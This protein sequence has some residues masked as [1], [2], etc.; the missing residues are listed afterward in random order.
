MNL[1]QVAAKRAVAPNTVSRWVDA[2]FLR[3]EPRTALRP[4]LVVSRD[5][6]ARF[7]DEEWPRIVQHVGTRHL[8]HWSD[9]SDRR[10][11]GRQSKRVAAARGKTVG[12]PRLPPEVVE[13][14]WELHDKGYK[15]QRIAATLSYRLIDPVS[16]SQVQR[17]LAA[18]RP[19]F[20]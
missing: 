8:P 14:I 9:L 2:G 15:Q 5:E 16:R 1:R 13:T 19:L 11:D 17:V 3:A 18:P 4:L 12:H 20:A 10:W 7:N 6:L